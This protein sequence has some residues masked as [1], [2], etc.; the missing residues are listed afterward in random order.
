[1]SENIHKILEALDKISA[2]I[3]SSVG[4]EISYDQNA[5][6]RRLYQNL[7]YLRMDFDDL[8][9]REQINEG[10]KTLVYEK[11]KIL[12]KSL[13]IS[14]IKPARSIYSRID[15][16][17]RLLAFPCFVMLCGSFGSLLTLLLLGLDSIL[18]IDMPHMMS[19]KL[20]RLMFQGL[21]ITLGVNYEIQGLSDKIYEY[22]CIV[23]PF[24]HASNLDPFL[25]L[26]TLPI[27]LASFAK[28]ELFLVRPITFET[29]IY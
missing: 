4:R 13:I 21:L 12:A 3:A 20:R 15:S 18:S 26:A 6:K 23:M 14:P 1:M 10:T 19:Q 28:K 7:E 9:Q 16:V 17:T 27:R 2:D 8:N 24:S 5:I 29:S 11:F 22:N 25:I